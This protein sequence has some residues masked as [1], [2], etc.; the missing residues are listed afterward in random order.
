MS[1]SET[2]EYTC[3]VS[4]DGT[5][6][7]VNG[8]SVPCRSMTGEEF[9]VELCKSLGIDPASGPTIVLK[10]PKPPGAEPTS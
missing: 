2:P 3:V 5:S 1:S 4:P 8:K 6:V 7:E 10:V 9:A